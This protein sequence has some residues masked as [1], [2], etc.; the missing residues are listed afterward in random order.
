MPYLVRSWQPIFRRSTVLVVLILSAC[1]GSADTPT[2]PLTPTTGSLTVTISSPGGAAVQITGPGSYSRALTATE[3]LSGLTPGAYAIVA[4]SVN[5]ATYDFA[6]GVAQQSAT[7]VAG[8]TAAAA[9]TYSA[10]TG[11]VTVTM[12]G[13]PSDRAGSATVTGQGVTTTLTT[14][15]TVARLAPGAYT[16]TAIPVADVSLRY[17]AATRTVT[18]AAGST[19]GSTVAYALPISTRSTTDRTDDVSG[20]QL[21]VLYAL[22]SDGVDRGLDT[23]GV[24]QRSVSSWQRW[25]SA[26]TTGRVLRLDTFGGGLD[27]QYV[28]LPRTDAVYR[29]FGA[30]I[31]DSIEKDLAAA[32]VSTNTQKLYLMYYDGGH[33]DRCGSAAYPPLLP[34][35]VAAIYLQGTITGGPNCNTNDF[36]ASPTSAPGYI[37]FVAAHETMHLLGL[38]SPAAPDYG[39]TGHTITD[40]SDLMYAGTATWT[41]SK[42]DQLRRNYFNLTGLGAG[43]LNFATSTFV[44]AQ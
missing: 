1:G 5:T 20:N 39:F 2:V 9:V 14:S 34:G 19:A 29:A 23:L 11:A 42:F 33:I 8:E 6:P 38:V 12:A 21:K 32:G 30:L 27:V 24:L 25:L 31:R 26:Q 41:P 22:P 37:D 16:I 36:P 10:T 15:G 7:V 4:S 35:R 17:A 3:T 18:V 13:L 44:I 28:R 40:P 43:I